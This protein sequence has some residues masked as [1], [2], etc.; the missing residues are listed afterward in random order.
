MRHAIAI[1]VLLA[2]CGDP[3]PFSLK[4][5]VTDGDVQACMTGSGAKA[6]S[7]SGVTMLC[8]AVV[9]IRI[10]APSDPTAPFI[11]VCK[12]LQ[13]SHNTR[14]L[15]AIGGVD[16]PAPAMPVHSQSLEVDMAVY[17]RSA[18]QTAGNGDLIC[19]TDIA[20]GAD[21]FPTP[22][23]PCIDPET[24]PAAPA[25]GGRAFY[26]PG[27]SETVVSL[28]C[29]DIAPLEDPT[30]G[31]KTQLKVTAGVNDFSTGVSV[32]PTTA[33]SL[34]VSV[35]EP[36]FDTNVMA[37]TLTSSDLHAL[38]RTLLSPVPSWG[39]SVDLQLVASACLEVFEDGAQTTAALACTD[40]I[41]TNPLDLLGVRL[42][43]P[44]LDQVLLALG[45]QTFPIQGLVVGL[46]IDDLGNPLPGVTIVPTPGNAQIKYMSADGTN[47]GASATTTRGVWVS[48]EAPYGTTFTPVGTM[49]AARAGFG[50]LVAGKVDIVIVQAN[51]PS[52]G[53]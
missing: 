17:P 36:T 27:D 13:P 46:A 11:S 4:F 7:C 10:F 9:S 26:H 50:G 49:T 21:G 43:K 30:C 37:Y 35:G 15:C 6:T 24:C 38:A 2:A 18:L 32:A 48:T 12:P 31:G 45:S 28:G 23:Q 47:F 29:T 53:P 5:R 22:P 33:N 41:G 1:A 52:S 20:F 25:I 42:A 44:A 40:Q 19:P 34:L 8:D 14:D 39:A 16:L 51:A 3:P